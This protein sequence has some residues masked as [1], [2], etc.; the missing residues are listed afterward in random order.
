MKCL[1]CEYWDKCINK[2]KEEC[3]RCIYNDYLNKIETSYD[4][5]LEF[6]KVEYKEEH[7]FNEYL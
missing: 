1:V 7:D 5:Y 4:N 2:M 6:E 3:Y